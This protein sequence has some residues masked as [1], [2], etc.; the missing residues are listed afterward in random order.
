MEKKPNNEKQAA[1]AFCTNIGV[2]AS[3]VNHNYCVNSHMW[4][5]P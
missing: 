5:F 1:M 2:L 3:P 4:Y